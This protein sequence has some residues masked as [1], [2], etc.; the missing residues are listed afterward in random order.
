MFDNAATPAV[1]ATVSARTEGTDGNDVSVQVA[2]GT[3]SG[4]FKLTVSYKKAVVESWDNLTLANLGNV[5]SA[6]IA[7]SAAAGATLVP[8]PLADT[9]LPGGNDGAVTDDGDY[10]GDVN[11]SGKRTG[12]KA[13]ETVNVSFVLCAQQYSSA[14]Q[15]ALIQHCQDAGVARGRICRPTGRAAKRS[16][17]RRNKRAERKTRRLGSSCGTGNLR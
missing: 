6:Y 14:I 13:L 17:R 2:A 1:S 8:A 7:V 16:A 5:Q 9:P 10:I 4:T 12:L 3:A 15:A 11:G